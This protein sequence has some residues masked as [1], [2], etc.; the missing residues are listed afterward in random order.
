MS[1]FF[2]FFLPSFLPSFVSF[3]SFSLSP[4]SF[5]SL[6]HMVVLGFELRASHLLAGA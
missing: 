2:F 5:L 6:F 4:S 3:F 1:F